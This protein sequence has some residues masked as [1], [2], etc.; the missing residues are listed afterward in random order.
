MAHRLGHNPA[1]PQYA[2]LVTVG[3]GDCKACSPWPEHSGEYRRCHDRPCVRPFYA[4]NGTTRFVPSA[5]DKLTHWRKPRR[6]FVC[7]MSDLF[8]ENLVEVRYHV[9]RA[10][11]D[12][13]QHTYLLL[14][15]RPEVMASECA[16][17]APTIGKVLPP[18]WWVGVTVCNQEEADAKI[19]HLLRIP[20]KVRWIS[21]E[22]LLGPLDI[23]EH[24]P[25]LS[26]VVCGGETGPNARPVV[27]RWVADLYRQCAD[28]GVPFF[29]KRFPFLT[30]EGN[31]WRGWGDNWQAAVDT[32]EYPEV[33]A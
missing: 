20:A 9:F 5:L 26:W 2:G 1:T 32:R 7:S 18:N 11:L 12:A 3:A 22:P 17:F 30:V 23:S 15:K 28:A 6:V 31:D 33:T 21:A 27:R 14:T 24:L 19:P 25:R 10:M 4:F 29:A 13:P 16:L 8:H